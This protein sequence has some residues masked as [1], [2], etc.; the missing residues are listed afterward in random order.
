MTWNIKQ[1]D[2]KWY[3]AFTD[4]AE[5]PADYAV[6][7]KAA[8][9]NGIAPE[10]I[11]S[12]KTFEDYIKKNQAAD[13]PL[14][15]LELVLEPSFYTRIVIA[16]D[17]TRADLYIRKAKGGDNV[18]DKRI[19]SQALEKEHELRIR[20]RKEI[21]AQIDLFAQSRDREILIPIA[22]AVLPQRGADRT[23]ITHTV[24]LPDA[25]A[26]QLVQ[27]LRAVAEILPEQKKIIYDDNFPLT[28]AQS[29]GMAEKGEKLFSFSKTALGAAGVDIYGAPI[30]GLPGNDP[31]V[32]DMRNIVYNG[33][34]LKAEASGIV[35][36]A[37][38][39]DGLRV[40]IIP[41][42]DA[43]V[44]AV[45][46][47]NNMAVSLVLRASV[48]AGVP[49][50]IGQLK[51]TLNEIHVP[52]KNYT[53]ERLEKAIA[54]ARKVLVSDEYLICRGKPPVAPDSYRFDWKV[55]FDSKNIAS[56]KKNTLILALTFL[57]E[58][59]PGMD[60]FDNM[61]GIDNAVPAALP[62]YD[63]TIVM[64]KHGE[65]I[66]F[67][68][69]V[70]GELL[71]SDAS[72]HVTN[73]KVIDSDVTE[74][75]EDVLFG[76]DLVIHGSIGKNRKIKANGS[77][78]I[79]GDAG[80]SLV[81]TKESLIMRGGIQGKYRGTVWAKKNISLSFA[82]AARLLAGGNIT[83]DRYCFRCSVV[84]NG[85]LSCIGEQ[86]SVIGGNVHAA[87][88]MQVCNLGDRKKIRT[89]I[90][91]GQDY[92]IKDKI[93]LYEKE[94]KHNAMEIHQIDDELLHHGHGNAV[95][96]RRKAALLKQNKALT[97]E[98]FKLKEHFESHIE[99]EIRV[100]GTAYP[101]VVLESHGRYYEVR[102]P[103]VGVVFTFATQKGS[104][105][106]RP[107]GNKL[108]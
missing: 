19:I 61:I 59:E 26:A 15:P 99:S 50:S 16:P 8:A 44:Q 10:D 102:K 14:A 31:F 47:E 67:T 98:V 107:I 7:R 36:V 57:K 64:E 51:K 103:M 86:G 100:T 88:G 33:D 32:S 97:F 74:D 37:H 20:D 75:M 23:L 25:E 2:D 87:C 34:S 18:I 108:H 73:A 30:P 13:V 89:L 96:H 5:D 93:E 6:L 22:E 4:S 54:A 52:E 27:K 66:Q 48:G 55:S 68:A 62:A 91:F 58:G 56:V 29:L 49:F 104:I 84:T 11:I 92:L 28:E 106:C 24:P 77:L 85:T 9:S 65:T 46:R 3:I 53:T 63:D 40:R 39:S 35:L 72:L 1:S 60:V 45:V 38:T 105:V 17:N 82:E 41:Y 94:M 101:G 42:K 12:Q 21:E 95:L 76:G 70:S 79:D 90:S 43:T 81:Y 80:V 71:K 69:A 78:T 83:I